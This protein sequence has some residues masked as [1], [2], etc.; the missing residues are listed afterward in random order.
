MADYRDAKTYRSQT[1]A[2]EA[3]GKFAKDIADNSWWKLVDKDDR[4]ANFMS[5]AKALKADGVDREQANI[6]NARLYENIDLS[7]LG[8]ADASAA[9]VRQAILGSGIMSLN[10]V[11]ACED[12]LAAKISKNKP[13]PTFLTSGG[14]WKAQIQARRL[15][16]FMKGLF[17]ET[18]VFEKAKAVFMDALTYGTGFLHTYQNN[19]GRLDCER[20]MPSEIYVDAFDGMYQKPRNMLRRKV[21]SK[22]VLTNMFPAFAAEIDGAPP[23]PD[24]TQSL[25][26]V[27]V[28]MVEVWEGWH[29]SNSGARDGLHIIAVENCE[30]CCEEWKI[31]CFPIIPIRFKP[32]TIGYWG[33]GVAESLTGIQLELNRLIRSVSEQL[34]RKGRGRVFVAMGSKV[35]PAHLTNGIGDVIYYNGQPPVVDN[36]NA[37]SP[38]EFM[39]IDRLYQRAFQEVGVSELSAAAKKPSGLDAAVALRE[40]SDIESERFALIHQEWEQLFLKYAALCIELISAQ[41]KSGNKGYKIKVP[42]RRNIIEVDWSDINLD[43]DSYIMQM[44]PVSSLPQTPAARYAKVKEMMQDGFIDKSVAQRLLEYPDI[45]AETNLGNAAIDDADATIS[46]VLDDDEPTID[47]IQPYQSVDLIISRAVSSYLYARHFPD[48]EEERLAML[49]ALIDQA[50]AMKAE[51]LTPP[52]QPGGEMPAEGPPMGP[53]GAQ[54]PGGAPGQPLTVNNTL[55]APPQPPAPVAPPVVA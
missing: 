20:V 48:I 21:M 6:K 2:N 27:R 51:I 9:I 28:P 37:V 1:E 49:R 44:F 50:T 36:N 38:E 29:L 47:P 11:A 41:Y 25:N 16:K 7:T 3:A 43:R 46:K 14:S 33:K 8:A 26:Q 40:Y 39:Q 22:D 45:E 34:R 32:R 15:D 54:M 5:F 42:G 55:N 17:Y 30:L 31:D 52:P 23:P 13:R 24:I 18:S 4:R 35:N 53:E 19:D 10:V 12:T